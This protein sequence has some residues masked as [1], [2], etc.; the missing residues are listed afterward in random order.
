M[1]LSV[2]SG[3]AQGR[4]IRLFESQPFPQSSRRRAAVGQAEALPAANQPP[5]I[6]ASE[7]ALNGGRDLS[8]I[9]FFP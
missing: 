1:A 6:N 2:G 3:L 4:P 7:G 8:S 5:L 9:L